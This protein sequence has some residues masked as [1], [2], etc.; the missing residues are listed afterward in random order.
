MDRMPHIF[1]RNEL[2]RVLL[3]LVDGL[4]DTTDAAT[5][6]EKFVANI[7]VWLNAWKAEAEKSGYNTDNMMEQI[8]NLIDVL[9]HSSHK[10]LAELLVGTE[11]D[12]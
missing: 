5:A 2:D 4:G 3:T 6:I 11:L 12:V 8:D 10:I 1:K 9:E 7:V